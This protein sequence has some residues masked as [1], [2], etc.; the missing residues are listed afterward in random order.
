MTK[1]VKKPIEI[2]AFLLGT[3]TRPDWAEQDHIKYYLGFA[4][5]QTL[6]GEMRAEE[7][8]YII[9]GIKGEIYPCKADIFKA[10]Y[11]EVAC[12]YVAKVGAPFD[13]E[14]W[15]FNTGTVTR[16]VCHKCSE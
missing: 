2:E 16:L 9:K 15:K 12:A 4:I 6:E 1:Y 3:D 11:D 13:A 8:D 7:G 14:T 10:S 5:I